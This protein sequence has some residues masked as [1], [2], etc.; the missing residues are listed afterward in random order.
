MK[1]HAVDIQ[2]RICETMGFLVA[3]GVIAAAMTLFYMVQ[4]H[5]ISY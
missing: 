1:S 3:F 4:K 5:L 2:L